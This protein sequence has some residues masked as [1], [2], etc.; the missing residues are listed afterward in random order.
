MGPPQPGLLPAGHQPLQRVLA[1][2]LQ[3]AIAPGM[4][5][6]AQDHQRLVDEAKQQI[7]HLAPQIVGRTYRFRRLQVPATPEHRQAAQQ[8]PL[9]LV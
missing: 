4:P 3:H 7:Q 5:A 9:A 6:P 1:H 2:R 8:N